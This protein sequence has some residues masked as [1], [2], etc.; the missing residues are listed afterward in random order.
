MQ[1]LLLALEFIQLAPACSALL[2]ERG[3]LELATKALNLGIDVDDVD[4]VEEGGDGSSPNAVLTNC[5]A[6]AL[7]C[8]EGSRR[9]R[10]CNNCS[11]GKNLG[12]FICE[13]I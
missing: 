2:R 10:P 6:R 11:N 1:E 13:N 5:C 9:T 12:E 4:S 7:T 8:C 3:N